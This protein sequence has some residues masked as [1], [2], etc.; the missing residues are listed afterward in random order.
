M[1][2]RMK[3][4]VL[5]K[6]APV[7]TSNFDETMCVAGARI[8]APEPAWVRLHPVPFRDLD[9][10]RK[11]TKYQAV[12]VDV[13]RRRADRRPESWSPIH[14]SIV[15]TESMSTDHGWAQRRGIVET[16]GEAN[17]CDLVEVNRSGSGPGTPSLA[18]VRPIAPPK[19]RITR[20]DDAQLEEWGRRAA[21]A[22][23]RVS[24]FDDPD[25]R[26]PEFEVVPWRFQYEFQC[27]ASACNGHVQTIVDWEVLALWRHV[28]HRPDWQEQMRVKFEETLWQ[29]RDS[30][31][32]VG[33]QEQHPASFLVLGVFWPPAGG[34]QGV[35]D[36]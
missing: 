30:R 28:R 19:L 20:R 8:D 11:F 35:F 18:V 13:I 12:D 36:L 17:M 15:P 4:L 6:A 32:F 16:L 7:L 26:K 22:E 5:V 23:S 29:G 3:V 14:G 2:E 27:S 34:A 10:D 21:A 24:L 31:L 1:A 33:N 9:D 25:A